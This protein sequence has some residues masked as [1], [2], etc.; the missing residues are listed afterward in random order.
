MMDWLEHHYKTISDYLE[1]S[2]PASKKINVYTY[3]NQDDLSESV[4]GEIQGVSPDGCSDGLNTY[5][6]LT[7]YPHELIHAYSTLLG[8][9]PLFFQEGLACVVGCGLWDENQWIERSVDIKQYMET[10][11]FKQLR[12]SEFLDVYDAAAGFTSFVIDHYGKVGYLEFYSRTS[13][14]ESIEEIG[15]E[16]L[17]AFGES[18]DIAVGRWVEGPPQS[19]GDAC[20]YLAE[21]ATKLIV[22]EEDRE[23][24]NDIGCKHAL[25]PDTEL[26]PLRT[27]RHFSLSQKNGVVLRVTSSAQTVGY[28]LGCKKELHPT[29]MLFQNAMGGQAE[30]W[31]D[32]HEGDYWLNVHSLFVPEEGQETLVDATISLEKDWPIFADRCDSALVQNLPKETMNVFL[33]GTFDEAGDND[34]VDGLPD[35]TVKFILSESRRFLINTVTTVEESAEGEL[36][37]VP[38]D[39]EH[40]AFCEDGCPLTEPENCSFGILGIDSELPFNDKQLDAGVSYSIV[41]NGTSSSRGYYFNL[42]F[43]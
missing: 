32:V 2:L 36:I 13:W 8:N 22:D 10:K 40:I 30:M 18:L 26:H 12:G 34:P 43:L 5:S 31:T 38:Y 42:L 3:S 17:R 11:V 14:D 19:R 39:G 27:I 37:I 9:P 23:T 25:A 35:I 28:I 21:C 15:I 41:I 4:C 1:V 24:F 16:F 33:R 20:L 6:Y 7:Y 29:R